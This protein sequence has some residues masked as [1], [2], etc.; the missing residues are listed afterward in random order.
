MAGSTPVLTPPNPDPQAA[1]QRAER[2]IAELA[3]P[4]AD[5]YVELG[6][7]QALAERFPDAADSLARALDLNPDHVRARILLGPVLNGLGRHEAALR[8]AD[9]L[10]QLA[11]GPEAWIIR[12]DALRGLEDPEAAL[13]SYLEAAALP[14]RR[15]EALIK[16]A[17]QHM[18]LKQ[19]DE[20]LAAY[21]AVLA[22]RPDDAAIQFDRG[23]LKLTCRDYEGGWRDYQARFRVPRFLAADLAPLANLFGELAR[24]LTLDDLRGQR[25][26]VVGEQGVGDV[27]M[28]ASMFPDL[29]ALGAFVTFVC[30]RRLVGLLST[31]FPGI[32]ILDIRAASLRR[33]EID[34]VVDLGE[35]AR[36]FRSRMEDFPGTPYLAPREA[37]GRR[38]AEAMG[39]R[40]R[41]LRV[42]LSWRGGIKDAGQQRRS[43]T[44]DQLAPI[45]ALPNCE[46]VSLQ[47]GEVEEEVSAASQ[48]LGRPIRVFPKAEIDDFEALAGLIGT[49]DVVVSVQNTVIHMAGATGKA[50][51]GL[52]PWTPEWR[53]TADGPTMPWYSSVRLYRQPTPGD[54]AP[55][56]GAATDALEDRARRITARGGFI[57]T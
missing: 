20:A 36:L 17:H 45:L 16:V 39:P 27:V 33:S 4:E 5:D 22:L 1:A 14:A 47:Y 18:R 25:I 31:S 6:L 57:E 8:N 41:A 46:V 48:R 32:R 50:C 37:V 34:K 7:A 52:L 24:D 12:G 21:D 54:W 49:L 26:L 2:R 3:H 13:A 30:D 29:L 15:G 23:W 44:L 42:G 38:W 56:I 19:Y 35:L 10:L 55:V 40:T 28:F 53:Y 9:R 43:L 51:L 11:P